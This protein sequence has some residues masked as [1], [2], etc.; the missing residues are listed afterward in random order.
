MALRP[1]VNGMD[2][3]QDKVDEMT[4]ALL[5]LTRFKMSGVLRT[6]KRHDWDTMERLHAKGY[7]ADPKSKA[8]SVLFSEEGEKLS[9]E[10]FAKH[11][12]RKH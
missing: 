6:W 7:I 12:A 11:F 4:L 10:L 1:E 9:H 8:E 5:W 3:D 2:Y